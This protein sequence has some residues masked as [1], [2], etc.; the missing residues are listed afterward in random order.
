MRRIAALI[1]VAIVLVFALLYVFFGR[2]AAVPQQPIA[3][4]HKN[5][6]VD[7]Q[8]PCLY[9]HRGADVG[10][11]AGIPPLETCIGCH[12][13]VGGSTQAQMDEIKKVRDAYEGGQPVNWVKVVYLPDHVTFAHRPHVQEGISCTDCHARGAPPERWF[14]SF[15][16]G[17]AWCTTCHSQ[18]QVSTQ[19]YTC[20]K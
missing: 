3:F 9:C 5:H 18:R 12:R 13:S 14:E 8:I 16:P 1:A 4:S 15:S 17:M 7:R 6:N 2:A 11:V 19:C 20:H 10:F